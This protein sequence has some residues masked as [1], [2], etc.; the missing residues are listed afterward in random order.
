MRSL[1]TI[2]SL[3]ILA[4]A[5]S[6]ANAAGIDVQFSRDP[7]H[8]Q[9]GAAV[10]GFAGD[11]WNDFLGNSGSGA[12]RNTNGT[13][14]GVSLTFSSYGVYESDP[15]YTQFTGTPYANLMQGYLYGFTNTQATDIKFSG[16]VAG[17]E[18]GFWVYT[19][20]DDN[21]RGR[22]ISLTANGGGAQV[23][24]QS[25]ATGFVLG[26]NYVYL[27]S[28]A[29]ASGVVDLVGSDLVAEGNINGVQVAVVPEPSSI[30]LMMAGFAL[31]A[32]A[33]VRRSRTR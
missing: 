32:G 33:A 5:V 22:S 14:S 15:G 20:G 19:Q 13:A 25:N 27:T 7:G 30:V 10:V 3:A 8:Q 6:G 16:L 31:L 29:N 9:T 4:T 1:L 24:T 23:S 17:Q 28:T 2:A 18:Y 12:L 11:V 21:S 26:D